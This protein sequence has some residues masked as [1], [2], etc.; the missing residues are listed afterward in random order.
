MKLQQNQKNVLASIKRHFM[1]SSFA[2]VSLLQFLVTL[3]IKYNHLRVNKKV[4]TI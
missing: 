2:S 3:T 4:L 1:Q